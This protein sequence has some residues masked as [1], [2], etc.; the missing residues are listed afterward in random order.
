MP[1]PGT[2]YFI[3]VIKFWRLTN[4]YLINIELGHG[5]FSLAR[6]LKSRTSLT[7]RPGLAS[8]VRLWRILPLAFSSLDSPFL[9]KTTPRLWSCFS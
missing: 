9:T 5:R 1:G 4:K 7:K 6:S 2:Y 8:A 3:A